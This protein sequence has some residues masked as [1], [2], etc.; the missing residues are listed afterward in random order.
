MSKKLVEVSPSEVAD[1]LGFI[2]DIAEKGSKR[3]I[4][5]ISLSLT[6]S[7]SLILL[8]KRGCFQDKP[9]YEVINEVRKKARSL[10][11]QLYRGAMKDNP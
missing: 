7:E 5:M 8:M 10:A 9:F 2:H 11:L 4:D 1:V 6:V 3:E